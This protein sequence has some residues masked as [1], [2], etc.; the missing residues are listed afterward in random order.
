VAVAVNKL[1]WTANAKARLVFLILDAPPQE[2]PQVLAS[3]QRSIRKAAAQG[4]RLIPSRPAA[5]TKARNT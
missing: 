1:S 4:I 3:L 5:S 2:N